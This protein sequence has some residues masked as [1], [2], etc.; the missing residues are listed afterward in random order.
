MVLTLRESFFL[1]LFYLGNGIP[2]FV[3]VT[4]YAVLPILKGDVGMSE[5][6][7]DR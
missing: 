5:R 3:I 4:F 6:L 2:M 7:F 1:V